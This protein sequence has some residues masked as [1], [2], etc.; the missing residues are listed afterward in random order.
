MQVVY[1]KMKNYILKLDLAKGSVHDFKLFKDSKLIFN[2][3][4][5]ILVDKGYIGINKL[6]SKIEIG[7]KKSKNYPLKD[8]DK[9]KNREKSRKRISIE[10]LFCHL[11]KFSILVHKFRSSIKNFISK[12]TLIS[13]FYNF[14]KSF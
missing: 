14:E 3:N 13:G 7:K 5:N 8:E 6:N 9:V 1:N 2:K 12:F 4:T 11:K 10:N